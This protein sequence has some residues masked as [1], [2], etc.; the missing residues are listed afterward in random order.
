MFNGI[1]HA[2]QPINE[3]FLPPTDFRCPYMAE[4]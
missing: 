3:T 2:P 4:E 1:F